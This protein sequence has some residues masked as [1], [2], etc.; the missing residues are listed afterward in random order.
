MRGVGFRLR[1]GTPT[2][3]EGGNKGAGQSV[4]NLDISPFKPDGGYD[5]NDPLGRVKLAGRY[6]GGDTEAA[7]GWPK[8][9]AA[10]LFGFNGTSLSEAFKGK[11]ALPVGY[12]EPGD[13]DGVATEQESN[14]LA[15]TIG[16]RSHP[17]Y[18]EWGWLKTGDPVGKT[19]ENPIYVSDPSRPA[20]PYSTPHPVFGRRASF[21]YV[22]Q[23]GETPEPPKPTPEPTPTP[24]PE[25]PKPTP[26]REAIEL[27]FA[28]L[29]ALVPEWKDENG[30]QMGVGKRSAARKFLFFAQGEMRK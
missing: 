4:I 15:Y 26:A 2:F 28:R 9:M 18:I 10:E 22:N 20:G 7:T 5:Y 1:P 17:F 12:W 8:G 6:F 16:S 27:V 30:V 13:W 23:L 3:W 14:D 11:G 21:Y 29:F 25:P 24:T 19:P